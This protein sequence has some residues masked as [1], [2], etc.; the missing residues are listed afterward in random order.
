MN[1]KTHFNESPDSKLLAYGKEVAE[2]LSSSS[3]Q[4]WTEHLWTMFGGCIAAQKEFGYMP[5]LGDTFFSFKQLVDFFEH[6]EVIR[7]GDQP[8]P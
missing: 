4:S 3:A 7:K 6:V 1:T 5:G 8:A 2:L